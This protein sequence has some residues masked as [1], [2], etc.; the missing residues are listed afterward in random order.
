MAKPEFFAKV[1]NVNYDLYGNKKSKTVKNLFRRNVVTDRFKNDPSSHYEYTIEEGQTPQIISE[2]YYDSPDY[3]WVI[4]MMN[5]IINVND[6]WPLTTAQ[7]DLLI[8]KRYGSVSNAENIAR[9]WVHK[10]YGTQISTETY[11]RMVERQDP[12]RERY[13]K[14]SAY[15]EETEKNEKNRVIRLLRKS[16]LE[17]FVDEFVSVIK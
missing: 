16:V 12:E 5:D 14:F 4:L 6:E 7:F 11:D 2:L 9:Y 8:E 15:D 3:Y 1:P 10:V 17:N 13:I